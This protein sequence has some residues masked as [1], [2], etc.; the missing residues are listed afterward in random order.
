MTDPKDKIMTFINTMDIVTTVIFSIE[1]IIKVISKGFI[2]SKNSYL[3]NPWNILDF[4]IVA[5]AGIYTFGI[6]NIS[7]NV[8]KVFRLSRVLRPLRLISRNEGMK[9]TINSLIRALPNIFNLVML[10]AFFFLLFGIMG[11]TLFKG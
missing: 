4:S 2:F 5:C 1:I 10:N 3:R 6:S 11:I 8:V 7:I 9:V